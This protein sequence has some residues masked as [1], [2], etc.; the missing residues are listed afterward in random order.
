MVNWKEDGK[1]D[2]MRIKLLTLMSHV[3][4]IYVG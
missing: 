1:G 4:V 2:V 3:Y